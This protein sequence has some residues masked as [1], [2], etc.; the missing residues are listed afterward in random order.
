MMYKCVDY[1][2]AVIFAVFSIWVVA[3][4]YFLDK[5]RQKVVKIWIQHKRIKPGATSS[6]HQ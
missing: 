5:Y 1:E 6:V 4:I 2:V 3:V